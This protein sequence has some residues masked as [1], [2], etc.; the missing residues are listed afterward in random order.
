M[1]SE[2]DRNDWGARLPNGGPGPLDPAD[3]IGLAFHWP[4]MSA[5]IRGVNAVKS[6]L[7]G[8]QRFHMD[9][10]GWSDIAYQVAVDQ[11]GNRYELRG[12]RT[13]SGANGD[14]DVNE[15]YGAV[16]LI[17]APDEKPTPLMVEGVR[18]VVAEHR[19][20][21]PNSKLLVGHQEIREGGTS[22]PGPDAMRAIRS[23]IFWPIPAKP[24]PKTRGRNVDAAL[25]ALRKASD[26]AKSVAKK[27]RINAARDALRKI[28]PRP[29][30]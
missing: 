1:P 9:T 22:C 14:E 12:L 30:G 18:R 4:G 15:A 8:W 20:L 2:F 26:A 11:D 6:A 17:L 29:K 27:A 7:R 19:A 28:T 24:A 5:P 10:R 21:F 13:Q 25:A 23:G 16:L 3:V